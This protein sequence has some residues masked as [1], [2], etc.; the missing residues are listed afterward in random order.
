MSPREQ[1]NKLF[2]QASEGNGWLESIEAE[3]NSVN[4]QEKL[5]AVLM[6]LGVQQLYKKMNY[7]VDFVGSRYILTLIKTDSTMSWQQS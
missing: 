3:L 1:A 2:R 5:Q 6:L 7:R 4:K